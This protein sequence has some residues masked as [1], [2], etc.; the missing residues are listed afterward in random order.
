M[1]MPILYTQTTPY[2]EYITLHRYS[3]L[4]QQSQSLSHIS[5]SSTTSP[6]DKLEGPA[7]SHTL[8]INT[9]YLS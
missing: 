6:T 8:N 1:L 4:L 9:V 7:L 3:V 2:T 5:Q